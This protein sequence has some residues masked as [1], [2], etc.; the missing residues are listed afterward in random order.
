MKS[1]VD[2]AIGL[3]EFVTGMRLPQK[4]VN[5]LTASAKSEFK[6]MPKTFVAEMKGLKAN[7]DKLHTLKRPEQVAAARLQ[8]TSA[9]WTGIKNLPLSKRPLLAR[10]IFRHVRVL[11]HDV[12]NNLVLT[13]RDLNA[14]VEYLVFCHQLYNEMFYQKIPVTTGQMA[15]FKMDAVKYFQ[16]IPLERKQFMCS[17]TVTWTMLKANYNRLGAFQQGQVKGQIAAKFPDTVMP[18]RQRASAS[19]GYNSRYTKSGR[20]KS[21]AEMQRE[22]QAKQNCFTIMNNMSLQNHATMLNTIENFGGTGNY[23]EVK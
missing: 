17:A 21:L 23:W 4:E 7:L 13:D 14:M 5:E 20:K 8:L 3:A 1:H 15:K 16:K 9:L 18:P 11:A 19:S 10:I 12:K 22:F 6:K 2:A